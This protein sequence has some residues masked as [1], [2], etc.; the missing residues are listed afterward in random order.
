MRHQELIQL[1]LELSEQN[2]LP[3][4]LRTLEQI[5]KYCR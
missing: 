4:P 2:I 3:V 1:V 5:N